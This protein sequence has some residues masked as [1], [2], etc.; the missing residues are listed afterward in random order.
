MVA[1]LLALREVM[2]DTTPLAPV[3]ALVF[4]CPADKL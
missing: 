4:R 3:I 2:L 1:P